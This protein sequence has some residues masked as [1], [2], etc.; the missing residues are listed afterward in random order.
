LLPAWKKKARN[1]TYQVIQAM[2]EARD[3]ETDLNLPDILMHENSLVPSILGK[4]KSS[5][6]YFLVFI[7]LALCVATKKRLHPQFS[8]MF[9]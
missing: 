4:I 3:N 5:Y 1:I 2:E 8:L 7:A 9:V 6:V